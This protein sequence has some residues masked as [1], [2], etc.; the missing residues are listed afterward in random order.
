MARCRNLLAAIALLL[1]AVMH[2]EELV[3]RVISVAD[4]DT[5]S[6]LNA[7]G[8]KQTVRFWGIDSP[9]KDQAMG[10]KAGAYLS[11]LILRKNVRVEVKGKDQYGRKIGKV[12]IGETYVNLEMVKQGFAWYYHQYAPHDRDLAAAQAEAAKARLGL[13]ADEQPMPPWEYR[14]LKR[15][16]RK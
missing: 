15:G 9:E 11:S 14:K 6:L 12:Y 4:G 2:G 16:K 10:R 5:M 1:V 8:E 7:E 13:W 3:G